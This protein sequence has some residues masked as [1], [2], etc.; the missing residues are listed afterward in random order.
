MFYKTHERGGLVR[1]QEPLRRQARLRLALMERMRPAIRRWRSLSMQCFLV[2]GRYC[3]DDCHDG[4]HQDYFN[5]TTSYRRWAVVIAEE[6]Y[7]S[8]WRGLLEGLPRGGS[9]VSG[10]RFRQDDPT[11]IWGHDRGGLDSAL[12]VALGMPPI[13]A[14]LMPGVRLVVVDEEEGVVVVL[15]LDPANLSPAE[16]DRVSYHTLAHY[17][18]TLLDASR[19]ASDGVEIFAH[20]R[21]RPPPGVWVSGGV[22]LWG[23]RAADLLERRS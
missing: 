4:R 18:H 14:G 3:S 12:T 1:D 15:S 23:A 17:C 20:H 2:G 21:M 13:R 7:R 11:S 10:L 22:R 6:R 5:N 8:I 9:G 19:E 16:G